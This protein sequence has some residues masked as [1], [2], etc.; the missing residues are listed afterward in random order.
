MTPKTLYVVNHSGGK[1][2]QA[3]TTYLAARVPH[4]DLLI[5]HAPLGRE[6]WPGTIEHIEATKPAD[7]PLIF[8]PVASGK[9]LLDR[10]RERRQF[11]D[12]A[13]R[14]CTS[15]FKRGPIEREI[16]RYLKAHPEYEGRAVNCLGIRADE[17]T[18]RK[19]ANLLRVNIRLSVAGR[20]VVDWYPIFTWSVA[21]VFTTIEQAGQQPHWAYAEGMRRLSCSFCIYSQDEDYQTAARLR[22]YLYREYCDVEDETGHTLSPSRRTLREIVEGQP[23]R[24]ELPLIQGTLF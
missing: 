23:R 19:K 16:R 11:P 9:R 10:V 2:S 6:E 8:A 15:D 21:D 13:R 20:I 24:R 1:D 22:P 7:V 4:E 17:S 12:P 3:M 18:E 14:W 5:V